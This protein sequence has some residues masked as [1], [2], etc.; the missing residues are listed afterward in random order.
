MD[1]IHT[2]AGIV[3]LDEKHNIIVNVCN[4]HFLRMIRA[5]D[6][7]IQQ[8]PF[9]LD[10]LP[11]TIV[12]SE[13]HNKLRTC[14]RAGRLQDSEQIY[15]YNKMGKSWRLTLAVVWQRSDT[16]NPSHIVITGFEAAETKYSER[17]GSDTHSARYKAI[18][19]LA[20]DAIITMDQERRITLFNRA[21]ETL[22]GY[23][24]SEVIGQ[25][26][27]I[28]LPEHL[29]A[30]HPQ[31]VRAFSESYQP[32]LRR[33]T[34]PRM[35]ETNSV[36]GRHRNGSLVPVEVAVS[37][38]EMAGRIEFIAIVRDI[39]DRVHLIEFLKKEAMTDMLTGLPNRRQFTEFLEKEF[40]SGRNFSVFIL[41]VDFFKVINDQYGHDAGDE[42]LRAIA[43]AGTSMLG[44]GSLFAR[45]G[46]EEFVAALPG[47]D[48]DIAYIISDKVRQ[49]YESQKFDYVWREDPISFTVSIGVATR[50]ENDVGIDGVMKRADR[51]LYK[52]KQTGRNR[53]EVG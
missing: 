49:R 12:Q 39:S 53:V 19:S 27:E 28:L 52:A 30:T 3:Q 25:L 41:D 38:I 40:R 29:R 44:V 18:V 6:A 14:F 36:F 8:A 43:S 22:F 16:A 34:A 10:A 23:T 7:N 32:R 17:E 47:A 21:A 45:W 9:R 11:D 20:Y 31:K 2:C 4:D 1:N 46:G 37:K 42:V 48:A 15:Y 51:A 13:F 24:S 5:L 33:A 35:D 50:C 26:V